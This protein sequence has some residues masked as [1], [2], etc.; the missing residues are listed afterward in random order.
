[1]VIQEQDKMEFAVRSDDGKGAAEVGMYEVQNVLC[2]RCSG[3]RVWLAR[4]L[5]QNARFACV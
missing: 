5:G 4:M 2:S 3:W 1:M